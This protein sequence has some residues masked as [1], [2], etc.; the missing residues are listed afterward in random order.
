MPNY[1]NFSTK[2]QDDMAGGFI[3]SQ[4]FLK[5]LFG[6]NWFTPIILSV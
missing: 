4:D 6:H 1:L 2:I 3:N 5:I